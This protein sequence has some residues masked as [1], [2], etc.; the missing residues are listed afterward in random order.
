MASTRRPGFPRR[1]GRPPSRQAR[2]CWK[3]GSASPTH[4]PATIA[5]FRD[6]FQQIVLPT[7]CRPP[8]YESSSSGLPQRTKLF[9]RSM[10]LALQCV[11]GTTNGVDFGRHDTN[12]LSLMTAAVSKAG[13]AVPK[14]GRPAVK[15][16]VGRKTN[17]VNAVSSDDDSTSESPSSSSFYIDFSLTIVAEEATIVYA[18]Q[19]KTSGDT[20]RCLHSMLDLGNPH[21]MA[22]AEWWTEDCKPRPLACEWDP[23][24]EVTS[25]TTSGFGNDPPST[26]LCVAKA[27]PFRLRHHDGSTTLYFSD[28]AIAQNEVGLLAGKCD[29][30]ALLT[31]IQMSPTLTTCRVLHNTSPR[32]WWSPVCTS[33]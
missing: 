7:R 20:H 33:S 24:K 14:A 9:F 5:C 8:P 2:L 32:L 16:A 11:P 19:Q 29:M 30:S 4:V 18:G 12:V 17:P 31:D 22:G 6:K 21:V 25:S 23:I 26:L 13:L 28:L 15:R 10:T 1:R 27:V 3:I